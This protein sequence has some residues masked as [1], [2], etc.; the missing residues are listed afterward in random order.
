MSATSKA[1]VT[2]PSHHA[3]NPQKTA[4]QPPHPTDVWVGSRIRT[5]REELGLSQ[6]QLGEA[7]GIT[8]QQLQKYEWGT[9]RVS[10]SRLVEIGKALGCGV[11]YFFPPG[12]AVT[13]QTDMTRF[14]DSH[15]ALRLLRAFADISS[16][17]AREH[18]LALTEFAARIEIAKAPRPR[19]AC[20]V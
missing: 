17:A 20:R 12:D 18:L 8:F 13:E 4:K 6:W 16:D 2:E 10:C 19:R 1:A 9:N 5:R 7:L 3:S 15:Q 11:T 14:A